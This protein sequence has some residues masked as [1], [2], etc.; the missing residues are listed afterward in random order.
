M[1]IHKKPSAVQ[2]QS[3]KVTQQIIFKIIFCSAC[4]YNIPI[5][6]IEITQIRG[7]YGRW[8]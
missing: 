6:Q 1:K 3:E 2:N 7:N 4:L 8:F 5:Q